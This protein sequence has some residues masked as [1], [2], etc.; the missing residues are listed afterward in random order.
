MSK[1]TKFEVKKLDEID[2]RIAHI[3]QYIKNMVRF[4]DDDII[5][6]LT[7]LTEYTLETYKLHNAVLNHFY[8][9]I[10]K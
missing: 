7:T 4:P 1:I 3:Y 2:G 9:E 8:E 6:K 5:G 10:E